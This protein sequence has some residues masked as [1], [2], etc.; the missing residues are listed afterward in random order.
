MSASSLSRSGWRPNGARNQTQRPTGVPPRVPAYG[1]RGDRNDSYKAISRPPRASWKCRH[2]AFDHAAMLTKKR[3]LDLAPVSRHRHVT[4]DR[5][6]SGG[7]PSVVPA[8]RGA[9]ERKSVATALPCV[10]W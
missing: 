8:Q 3:R 5:L 1:R 2:P 10:P 6:G 9:V 7:P 4:A